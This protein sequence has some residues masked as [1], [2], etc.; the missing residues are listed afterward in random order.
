MQKREFELLEWPGGN[1]ECR[2][3]L[4]HHKSVSTTPFS[5][6]VILDAQRQSC[7]CGPL[8]MFHFIKGQ[9]GNAGH[10]SV[11]RTCG[12]SDRH[13]WDS[14]E[15]S[16]RGKECVKIGRDPLLPRLRVVEKEGPTQKDTIPDTGWEQRVNVSHGK[17]SMDRRSNRP[18][19]E[20][21][22]GLQGGPEPAC[23]CRGGNR[24]GSVSGVCTRR[25]L[26]LN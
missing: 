10:D 8:S 22:R 2:P 26:C 16:R 18:E 14:G 6:S 11:V 4:L 17:L 13:G 24:L 5:S 9:E 20:R 19:G 7:R 3:R 1:E 25:I 15:D 12:D 23:I 21:C